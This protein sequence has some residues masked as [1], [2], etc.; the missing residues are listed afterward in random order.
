M[1]TKSAP[2]GGVG[3]LNSSLAVD[4]F[5]KAS[6]F[7]DIIAFVLPRTFRRVS[8]ENRL[9]LNFIKILDKTLDYK[10][11]SFNPEISAKCCFQI[12]KRVSGKEKE[13]KIN[14][15]TIEHKDFIFLKFGDKDEFNQPTPPKGADF[16]FKAYGSNCGEIIDDKNKMKQ[17]R[18]KSWH[19]IKSN[20][21]VEKLKIS[22]IDLESEIKKISENTV[23]QNSIGKA[24]FIEVYNKKVK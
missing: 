19:W 17:L 3:W 15:R 13:R 4:F 14:K 20:I 16:V 11:P 1:K 7:A 21:D 9:P 2:L 10:P 12:W 8:L 23:R 24:D 5:Y 22:I 6:K 18:P